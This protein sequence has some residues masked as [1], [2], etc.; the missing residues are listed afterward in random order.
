MVGVIVLVIVTATV[1]CSLRRRTYLYRESCRSEQ[2]SASQPEEIRLPD[3]EIGRMPVVNTP[4]SPKTMVFDH[5]AKGQIEETGKDVKRLS[6]LYNYHD[7]LGFLE[8]VDPIETESP[9]TVEADISSAENLGFVAD[10]DVVRTNRL[11]TVRKDNDLEHYL[12]ETRRLCEE[13][14]RTDT[15]NETFYTNPVFAA[16]LYDVEGGR[17]SLD[18]MDI[19]LFIPPGAFSED[20]E[21]TLVY[22]Y[23]SGDQKTNLIFRKSRFPRGCMLWRC[24]RTQIPET[25]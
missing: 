16:G 13:A 7:N 20:K 22:L 3:I 2:A 18:K 9:I 21:P 8:D 5:G 15:W 4:P 12:S 14:K 19:D 6:L 23:V 24:L 17:L 1:H 11:A 10:E 25:S